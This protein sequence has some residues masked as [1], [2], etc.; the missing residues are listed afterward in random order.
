MNWTCWT[1]TLEHMEFSIAVGNKCG[2]CMKLALKDMGSCCA[3]LLEGTQAHGGLG[4]WFWRENWSITGT[5][6]IVLRCYA[7]GRDGVPWNTWSPRRY[8]LDWWQL[9]TYLWVGLA[10]WRCQDSNSWR[11]WSFREWNISARH[12]AYTSGNVVRERSDLRVVACV[13]G[14]CSLQ[15]FV[16]VTTE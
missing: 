1:G 12:L 3:S 7:W 11:G 14:W 16:L 10:A 6:R 8:A 15:S 9:L 4:T 13:P 5:L 2:A